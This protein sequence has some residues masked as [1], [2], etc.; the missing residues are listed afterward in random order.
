M[1]CLHFVRKGQDKMFQGYFFFIYQA[2]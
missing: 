2:M 1:A